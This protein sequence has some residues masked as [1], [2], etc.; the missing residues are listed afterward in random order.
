ML[1]KKFNPT[2]NGIRHRIGLQKNLLSK[3]N[4]LTKNLIKTFKQ[5]HGR[6]SFSGHISVRHKGGGCK[7]SF[8][9]IE[10]NN[11][12]YSSIVICILYD[13]FR[14]SFIS[15]N[16]D[17]ISNLFFYTT[18]TDSIFPGSLIVSSPNFLNLKLGYKTLLKNIPA[19]S[20]IHSIVK[21][22][23]F[24]IKYVRSAGTSSQLIQK[25]FNSC[26][27]R[28][29]S[30]SILETDV[31]SFATIGKVSNLKHN[32]Q[33]IGKAGLNRLKSIRPGTRGIAM[34]P[35]DHPHGGR[36]NGGMVPATPWGKPTRGKPTVKKKKTYE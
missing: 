17:L 11:K 34:N 30:G 4:R 29:P 6:S 10:N 35:V 12:I 8:R 2:N 27:I 18:A 9:K 19:G 3:S 33:V 5:F 25:I 21:N 22:N 1:L 16:F 20:I 13:P 23:D 26:K 28:L 15:L 31:N 32:Q 14:N 7:R 24:N 36:T